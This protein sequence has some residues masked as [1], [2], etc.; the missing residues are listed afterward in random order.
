MPVFPVSNPPPARAIL[1]TLQVSGPWFTVE[2]YPMQQ[3]YR[4]GLQFIGYH[5]I[6]GIFHDIYFN[7]SFGVFQQAA[8]VVA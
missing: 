7:N 6:A 2:F 3:Q 4:R 5:L 1:F 8:A